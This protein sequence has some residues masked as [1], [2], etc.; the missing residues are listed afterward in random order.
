[1]TVEARR[2]LSFYVTTS[3]LVLGCAGPRTGEVP[4]PRNSSATSTPSDALSQQASNDSRPIV[5][6]PGSPTFELSIG[7]YG[8]CELSRD[9][10]TLVSTL[11]CDK[12]GAL[13]EEGILFNFYLPGIWSTKP[14]TPETV[15][16]QIRDST[17]ANS[18][19]EES[20]AAPDSAG[21]LA[22]HITQVIVYPNDNSGQVYV[23]KVAGLGGAAYSMVY[24]KM[25]HGPPQYMR[26]R[27]RAWLA[28]NV[29]AYS[30][31][32]AAI[33]LED[34]WIPYLLSAP[35]AEH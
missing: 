30:R 27:I 12:I 26:D 28:E 8:P 22:F 24:S 10:E 16:L 25:F 18:F 1:M 15:A 35:S 23:V 3:L 20:F 34:A 32:L 19:V 14:F 17:R 21:G 5:L 9:L 29:G 31:E 11:F 7:K 6:R 13:G 4:S 33:K 2:W